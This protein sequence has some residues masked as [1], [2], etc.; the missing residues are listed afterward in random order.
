M[1]GV[2]ITSA[3]SAFQ[4]YHSAGY[5]SITPWTLVASLSFVAGFIAFWGL[6]QSISHET[7]SIESILSEMEEIQGRFTRSP[8]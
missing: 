3:V 8:Q 2:F 7:D 5:C 1:V 4:D 6:R